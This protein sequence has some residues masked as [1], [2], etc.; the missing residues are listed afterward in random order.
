MTPLEKL[1]LNKRIEVK[2]LGRDKYGK[3]SNEWISVVGRCNFIGANKYMG[4]PLQVTIN[5]TP[6]TVDHITKIKCLT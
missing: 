1:F 4:I 5:N 3:T 6:Y 2:I